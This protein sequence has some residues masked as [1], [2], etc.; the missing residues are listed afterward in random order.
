M[1]NYLVSYRSAYKD[2]ALK[3]NGVLHAALHTLYHNVR[4]PGKQHNER[5]TPVQADMEGLRFETKSDLGA[6]QVVAG[7]LELA[8]AHAHAEVLK[9][10]LDD[11]QVYI[12]AWWACKTY[13]G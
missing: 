1:P 2:V 13:F 9:E 11:T 7:Q 10:M 4:F 8:D 6:A 3:S 5:S 12:Y